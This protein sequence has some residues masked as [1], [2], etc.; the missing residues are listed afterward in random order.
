M[1]RFSRI[2]AVFLLAGT[3]CP[4]CSW[5]NREPA[6]PFAAARPAA[7]ED[8]IGGSNERERQ[9]VTAE[10]QVEQPTGWD[11]FSAENLKKSFKKAIGKGPNQAVAQEHF[12]SGQEL[13]AAQEYKAAAKEFADAAD[14]WPELASLLPVGALAG[15]ADD[16]WLVPALP[17]GTVARWDGVA[18]TV[19]EAPPELGEP[20]SVLVA[21]DGV[22]VDDTTRIWT[23]SPCE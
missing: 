5:L 20:A 7:G 12:R 2:S 9:V 10:A 8:G 21:D 23:V 19:L 3:L 13:Y 4:G 22:I 15:P 1:R 11:R 17:N 14:R 16:L 18:W 6:D